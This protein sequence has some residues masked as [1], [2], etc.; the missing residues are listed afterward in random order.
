M[1]LAELDVVTCCVSVC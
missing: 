1:D